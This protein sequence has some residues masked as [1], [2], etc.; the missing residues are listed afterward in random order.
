MFFRMYSDERPRTPPPSKDSRHKPVVSSG[1]GSLHGLSVV[2]CSMM[3]GAIGLLLTHDLV[4][5]PMCGEY[6]RKEDSVK[7]GLRN[8]PRRKVGFR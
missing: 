2:I 1:F 8:T 5:R 3:A 4:M 6:H 7:R